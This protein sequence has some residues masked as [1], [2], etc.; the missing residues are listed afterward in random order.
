M[1]LFFKFKSAKDFDRLDCDGANMSAFD[2]KVAVATKHK[3]EKDPN[4]DLQLVNAQVRELPLPGKGRG[5]K[6][7]KKSCSRVALVAGGVRREQ[8]GARRH[9]AHREARAGEAAAAQV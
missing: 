1:S 3:L 8:H 9:L 2:I 4:F 7:E 5:E 6:K